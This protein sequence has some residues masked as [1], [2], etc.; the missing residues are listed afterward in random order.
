MVA[1]VLGEPGIAGCNVRSSCRHL[2]QGGVDVCARLFTLPSP[3]KCFYLGVN[4]LWFVS[5]V[6]LF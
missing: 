6:K 2:P 5:I 4:F 3:H 1:K